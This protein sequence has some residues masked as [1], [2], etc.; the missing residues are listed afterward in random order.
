MVNLPVILT[1]DTTNAGLGKL[2]ASCSGKE[3][4]FVPVSTSSKSSIYTVS[5][6]PQ[7]QDNYTLAVYFSGEPVTNSPFN[8]TVL[9]QEKAT[10]LKF[11]ASKCVISEL[12]LGCHLPVVN[13]DIH[14][15]VDASRA[16]IADL[17]ITADGPS[18]EVLSQFVAVEKAQE[19][20]NFTIKYTP[21][22]P[23][24]HILHFTYGG[25]HIPG[26]PLR[27]IVAS[28]YQVP[29]V[30][31]SACYVLP[32]DLPLSGNPCKFHISTVGAGHGTLTVATRG[33]GKAVAKIIDNEN[34]IYSC[35]L[36]MCVA[37]TYSVDIMWNG[38][39]IPDS[40][41]KF[42]FKQVQ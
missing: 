27:F 39:Q 9:Q 18:G 16:G 10:T 25:D 5:F 3:T 15:S 7:K 36:T 17:I 6:T 22:V 2:T 14:C 13:S 31:A 1:A 20:S 12:P 35:E 33:P 29:A 11:D 23:G 40:P 24:E 28:E 8:V 19:K 21:S 4:G 34:G 32:E 30:I 37:G 42:C 41:Y 26:S 38:E